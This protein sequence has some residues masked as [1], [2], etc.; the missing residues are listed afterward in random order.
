MTNVVEKERGEVP[1]VNWGREG[2]KAIEGGVDHR[3]QFCLD[4]KS[5]RSPLQGFR[6][7]VGLGM[8]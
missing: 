4:S 3:N 7:G 5:N 1:D 6:K 8:G 2:C